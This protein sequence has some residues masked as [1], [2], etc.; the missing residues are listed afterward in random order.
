MAFSQTT[1][2]N[3]ALVIGGS[4]AGLL[5]AWILADH[6]EQVTIIE[7]DHYPEEPIS[8]K[9]VPQ[10]RHVHVLLTR[11]QQ[12]LEQFF[13]GLQAELADA[14]APS[15]DWT[16]DCASYGL[17]GW[18]KRFPSGLVSQACTRDLIEHAIRHRLMQNPRIHWRQEWEATGLLPN[19]SGDGVAGV[20]LRAR[21]PREHGV[22]TETIYANLI[23]DATGYNSHAP[24]WLTSLGYTEPQQTVIDSPLGYAS[25]LYQ[26]PPRFHADWKVLLLRSNA[27]NENRNGIIYPIEGNRWIVT[28]GGVGGDYP[29]NDEE[30]FLAFA[31]SLGSSQLYDAIKGA[32]PLSPIYG[33]QR[34]ANRR[35]HF[36]RLPR[37]PEQFIVVG[38]AVCTFN[39]IHGQGM[40]AAALGAQALD[41]CLHAHPLGRRAGLAR[42]FQ[43][44]ITSVIETP[45]AMAVG[46][47]MRIQQTNGAK[48]GWINRTLQWYM[49]RLAK[50]AAQTPYICQTFIE[51]AHLIKPPSV[52]FHPRIAFQVLSRSPV[53]STPVL[54]QEDLQLSIEA[55]QMSTD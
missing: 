13:P 11:G 52:F 6:F 2:N 15:V 8:R 24:E 54:T 36:E 32:E 43:Q 48:Q 35:R 26:R 38:D 14:G 45:W 1:E 39:P 20:H 17:A 41:E 21:R 27:P 47:D 55:A 30:G 34:I 50:H 53:C 16:A 5:S 31:R 51:V 3:H 42:R 46:E 49:E 37:W 4:I 28:L 18:I 12:I 7:R 29:P 22:D 44:Q 25:R 9:G 33:Y 19:Q 40:S 10:S 23:V